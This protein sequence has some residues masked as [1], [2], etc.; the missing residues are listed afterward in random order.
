M[1]ICGIHGGCWRAAHELARWKG[2]EDDDD[3]QRLT[4]LPQSVRAS[5]QGAR[6]T[7]WFHGGGEV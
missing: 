4:A 7:S 3:L 2:G 1:G 5:A 6:M